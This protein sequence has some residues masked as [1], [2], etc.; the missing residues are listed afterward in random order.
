MPLMHCIVSSIG[1]NMVV[2]AVQWPDK[3]H[4]SYTIIKRPIYDDMSE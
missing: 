2:F 3:P 1:L 4:T